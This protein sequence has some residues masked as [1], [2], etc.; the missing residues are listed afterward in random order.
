ME[1]FKVY[2]LS[3]LI[4]VSIFGTHKSAY[5]LSGEY[6]TPCISDVQPFDVWHLYYTNYSTV[7]NNSR[8]QSFPTDVGLSVGI[9]PFKKVNMEIGF[10][11]LEPSDNPLFL[12]AKIGTPEGVLFKGSPALNLGIFDVGATGATNY[13]IF[14]FIV[15]KTLPHNFGRIH[16]GY[17]MGNS[18]LLIS[19]TNEKQNTGYMIAY[20]NYL[21]AG[22]LQLVADYASGKN[23]IGGGGFGLTWYFTPDI[24][25][26]TGPVWF[27]DKGLNGNM[28]W[29]ISLGINF[30]PNH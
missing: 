22:K 18:S 19:S 15:G 27:N 13:N 6:W 17:Y 3:V 21:Y 11:V 10:D 29:T 2:G 25:L 28:K 9:L 5:A 12:N 30:G 24:T 23:I 14:D 7:E 4:L 16:V 8:G 26:T 20:D 1:R